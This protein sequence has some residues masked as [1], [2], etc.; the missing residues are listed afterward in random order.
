MIREQKKEGVKKMSIKLLE[1]AISLCS[2]AA[3]NADFYGMNAYSEQEQT[4]AIIFL[5]EMLKEQG[6]AKTIEWLYDNEYLQ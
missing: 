2:E 4:E 1:K 5:Y 6:E 3:E